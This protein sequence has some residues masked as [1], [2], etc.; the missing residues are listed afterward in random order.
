MKKPIKKEERLILWETL[1]NAE[2]T[3]EEQKMWPRNFAA[4]RIIE[5]MEESIKNGETDFF[6]CIC[7]LCIGYK[8][9]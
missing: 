2:K 9:E 7:I 3:L 8:W 5:A 1:E 6:V 4:K